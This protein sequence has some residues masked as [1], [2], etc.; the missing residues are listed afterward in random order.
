MPTKESIEAYTALADPS[1]DIPALEENFGEKWEIPEVRGTHK[2][3]YVPITDK[4][5]NKLML[6]NRTVGTLDYEK[7]TR[8]EC[9]AGQFN[10]V[11]PLK[12]G[13]IAMTVSSGNV[14]T[15]V[16]KNDDGTGVLFKGSTK[17]VVDV[18]ETE[19]GEI[20]RERLVSQ[21]T[22]VDKDGV[23][24]LNEPEK[25]AKFFE[26]YARP[27]AASIQDN[28]RPLYDPSDLSN[29]IRWE[30]RA[31]DT[32]AKRLPPLP[33]VDE[34][35]P[36]EAQRHLI[37][38]GLS[39]LKRTGTVILNEEMG[40][41]KTLQTIA[42]TDLKNEWPVICVVP[43]HMVWKW[44]RD[45]SRISSEERQ[46]VPRVITRPIEG[47]SGDVNRYKIRDDINDYSV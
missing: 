35:G 16:L 24:L 12:V 47:D 30:W 20:E 23:I 32:I 13:H 44:Y 19:N 8:H 46:I 21:V 1:V 11:L 14:P 40:M 17:K 18:E 10:P 9:T 36:L 37:L 26:M 7:I 27:L 33:G 2:F 38:A 25:A 45:Y 3:T 29:Q 5:I 15:L 41:G 28:N 22:V 6:E 34:P 31:M 4:Q 43:G 39:A 42:I